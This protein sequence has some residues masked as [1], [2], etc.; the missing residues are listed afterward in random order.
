MTGHA[1]LLTAMRAIMCA[2]HVI[3][4]GAL[5]TLRISDYDSEIDKPGAGIGVDAMFAHIRQRTVVETRH[6]KTILMHLRVY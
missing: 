4:Q 1:S 5:P 6:G 2:S 3:T